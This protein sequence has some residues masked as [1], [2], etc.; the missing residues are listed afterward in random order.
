MCDA[1]I[2]GAQYKRGAH[3]DIL[4]ILVNQYVPYEF[5]IGQKPF[6]FLNTFSGI[7]HI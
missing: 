1:E 3:R 5:Y 6:N 4:G 7:V 2:G